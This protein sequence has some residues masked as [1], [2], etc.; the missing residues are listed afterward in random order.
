M[1]CM[2]KKVSVPYHNKKKEITF[3]NLVAQ[4]IGVNSFII[5]SDH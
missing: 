5:S 1:Y 4:S 3:V 2:A